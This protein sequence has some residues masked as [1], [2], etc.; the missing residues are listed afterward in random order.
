MAKAGSGCL[1]RA[2]ASEV[3]FDARGSMRR[4]SFPNFFL[5]IAVLLA[6][7]RADLRA[8]AKPEM[9]KEEAPLRVALAGLVHGHAFGFFEQFQKRTDL[10]VVG[11]AEAKRDMAWRGAFSIPTWKRC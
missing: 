8:Q 5:M 9:K 10:Q 2:D 11:I 3:E 6:G 7:A 1:P 4:N